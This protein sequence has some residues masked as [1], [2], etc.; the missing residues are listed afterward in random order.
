MKSRRFLRNRDRQHSPEQ[1][2][3][4]LITM[5]LLLMLLTALS[6]SMV[7]AFSSDMLLNGYNRNSR[8][9]F[10]AA[11]AGNT[12]IRQDIMNQLTTT[13][14]N[15]GVIPVGSVYPLT[16]A[17]IAAINAAI[18]ASYGGG[19]VVPINS[20]I[21]GI[22]PPAFSESFHLYTNGNS[23]ITLYQCA[24]TYY[25]T[26]SPVP[27]TAPSSPVTNTAT[28][29]TNSTTCPTTDPANGNL[30]I[31]YAYKWAYIFHYNLTTTGTVQSGGST[32]VTDSGYIM[33][34][35]TS[36]DVISSFS[37]F[38]TFI[39]KQ[40]I[41]DAVLIGNTAGDSITGPQWTNGAWTFGST[42]NYNFTDTVSSVSANVGYAF[43][44]GPCNQVNANLDAN[45]GTTIS[46]NFPK[47][48]N[49]PVTAITLPTDDVNQQSAVI[50]GA[51]VNDDGTEAATPTPATLAASLKDSSGNY[52]YSSSTTSGVFVA[53]DSHNNITG[54]GIWVQGDASVTLSYSGST[55]QVYTISQGSNPSTVTTVTIT[56]GS[57]VGSGTTVVQTGTATPTSFNGVPTQNDPVTRQVTDAVLLYST[58]N[59]TSLSGTVQD[60]T[61]ITVTAAKNITIT[62][63][64]TYKT[65]VVN[66]CPTGSPAG[67]VPGSQT[68]AAATARQTLGIFTAGG[69]VLLDPATSQSN[70]SPDIEVD[71]SIMASKDNGGD[72]DYGNT[73]TGVLGITTGTNIGTLTI[74]GGRIQSRAMIY[75]DSNHSI[76]SR[77]VYFDQ[78]YNGTFAPPFFP[79]PTQTTGSPGTVTTIQRTGWVLQTAY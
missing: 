66:T 5:L 37:Q 31:T 22:N 27:T 65:P 2:G 38:G 11:D 8:A 49:H 57:T 42:Y 68:S 9:S 64:L 67:C 7:L 54:G 13:A 78:R 10:Y 4:A 43:S 52:T 71:A 53:A 35:V 16:S 29:I 72:C 45:N 30:P 51:G 47:G 40:T 28:A 26:L 25:S 46:P 50:T 18:I 55:S 77:D 41:C 75:T 58:G 23:P 73:C 3:I 15:G 39:D 79:R 74:A 33:V 60:N 69:S 1:S 61:G 48:F 17:Q 56:P 70:P 62:S 19:S 32:A 44:N 59:I 34:N 20:T 12:V 21:P 36:G 14:N 24:V 76:A 6:L 63:N